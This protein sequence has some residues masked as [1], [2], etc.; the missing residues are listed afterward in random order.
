M[1]VQS[2]TFSTR[3]RKPKKTYKVGDRRVLKSGKVLEY[4]YQRAEVWSTTLHTWLSVP[5]SRRGNYLYEWI[6]VK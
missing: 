5:N 6:E 2:M 1:A 4:R 3:V